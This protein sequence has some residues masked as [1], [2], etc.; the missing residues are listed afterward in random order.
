MTGVDGNVEG[1]YKRACVSSMSMAK[2]WKENT[3][4]QFGVSNAEMDGW[5]DLGGKTKA[6]HVLTLTKLDSER[7]KK[8]DTIESER[9][10]HAMC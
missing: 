10:K 1:I 2:T 4:E 8:V 9:Q 5:I 3:R 6:C 7:V